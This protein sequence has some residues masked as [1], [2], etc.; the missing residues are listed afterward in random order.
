MTCQGPADQSHCP[1][2]LSVHHTPKVQMTGKGKHRPGR[3]VKEH[4]QSWD[5]PQPQCAESPK[6]EIINSKGLRC[7]GLMCSKG[8]CPWPWDRLDNHQ[9][10]WGLQA[11][12][13]TPKENSEWS[14][15]TARWQLS[16]GLGAVPGYLGE[17]AYRVTTHWEHH[18]VSL[19]HHTTS[20]PRSILT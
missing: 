17:G 10:V 19:L 11:T 5:C 14:L 9:K 7:P 1:S 13:G 8:Q 12:Q 3:G 4:A 16:K 2:P 15:Q 20:T 6:Y 18:E